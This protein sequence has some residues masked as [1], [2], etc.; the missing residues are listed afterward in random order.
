MLKN[1]INVKFYIL[2]RFCNRKIFFLFKITYFHWLAQTDP[3]I[4]LPQTSTYCKCF[5]YIDRFM[6]IISTF[7]EMKFFCGNLTVNIRTTARGFHVHPTMS[8]SAHFVNLILSFKYGNCFKHASINVKD[9]SARG[10]K[11]FL[12]L[13]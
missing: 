10:S 12:S 1:K 6:W 9:Y 3:F 13:K 4:I 11:K 5:F 8:A 7:N 2:F